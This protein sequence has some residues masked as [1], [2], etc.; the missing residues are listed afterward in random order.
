MRKANQ[1]T[2]ETWN[3]NN[4]DFP[5]PQYFDHKPTPKHLQVKFIPGEFWALQLETVCKY[6]DGAIIWGGWDFKKWTRF[7]WDPTAEWWKI[8]REYINNKKV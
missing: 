3:H 1:C 7:E 6:A 2:F 5:S 4:I 8:T